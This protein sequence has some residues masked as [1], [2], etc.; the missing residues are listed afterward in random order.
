MTLRVLVI[1]DH[2]SVR[3]GLCTM[4]EGT[5]FSITG[6]AATAKA[7]MELLSRDQFDLLILDIRLANGCGLDL[8]KTV[9]KL[10]PELPVVTMS[11]F[12]HPTFIARAIALG[13]RDFIHK[14][15]S[16]DLILDILHR[17]TSNQPPAPMGLLQRVKST[18]ELPGTQTGGAKFPLTDREVQVMRQISLGLTNREIAAA[19]RISVETVKEHIQNVLRKLN[20]Y[21]RTAAAVQAVRQG[22]LLDL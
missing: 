16:T 5:D 4:L 17:A 8:L 18:M 15:Y 2:E 6:K 22:I 3:E 12:D 21:D 10:Y 9:R 7:A 11:I 1:D 20:A 13:A 19:L 14:E